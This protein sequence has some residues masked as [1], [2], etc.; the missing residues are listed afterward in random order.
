MNEYLWYILDDFFYNIIDALALG[1][2]LGLFIKIISLIAPFKSWDK[3]KEN[4]TALAIIWAIILVIFG[5]F[6]IAGY[7]ITG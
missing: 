5:V 3:I 4:T 7:F 2:S 1:V 6:I